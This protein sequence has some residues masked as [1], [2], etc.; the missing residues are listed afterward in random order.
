RGPELAQDQRPRQRRRVL[1]SQG[2]AVR[3]CLGT[4]SGAIVSRIHTQRRH[5]RFSHTT[6]LQQLQ[7]EPGGEAAEATALGHHGPAEPEAS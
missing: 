1:L 7:I 5:E 6:S 2:L 3:P 4:A